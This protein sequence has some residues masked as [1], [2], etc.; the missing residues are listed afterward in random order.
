M[1]LKSKK[2]FLNSCYTMKTYQQIFL[3]EIKI[4]AL[5][6]YLNLFYYKLKK[7]KPIKENY[8]KI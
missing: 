8:I 4:F 2:Y 3:E 5:R 6:K 7:Y 1:N